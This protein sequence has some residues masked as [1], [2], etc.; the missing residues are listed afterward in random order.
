M[1]GI[2]PVVIKQI[3]ESSTEGFS[4]WGVGIGI[5]SFVAIVRNVDHSSTKITYRLE[6]HTGQIDAH[7]WLEEGDSMHA[8]QVIVNA[9]ARVYGSVRNQGGSKTIMLFRLE[10][11]ANINELT[12]HLLE[13]LNTR[14][15]AEEASKND[16]SNVAGTNNEFT[17]SFGAALAN[18]AAG[19][20]N[21]GTNPHGLNPK[22]LAVFEAIRADKSE[23]G[24]SLQQLLKRF[25]HISEAEMT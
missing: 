22:Q 12:N 14:F 2:A 16:V 19:S 13:V 10:P 23:S 25:A 4:L 8:P 18:G 15:K 9:Y 1:Q 5:V 20:T 6:D 17:G 3:I 24:V 21:V 7:Y 11:M